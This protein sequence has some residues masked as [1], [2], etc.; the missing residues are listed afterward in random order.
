MIPR[1]LMTR[2]LGL[3]AMLGFE[4]CAQKALPSGSVG[5]QMITLRI[6]GGTHHASKFSR[7]PSALA[8]PRANPGPFN[9]GCLVGGD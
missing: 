2:P 9:L 3:D 6:Q 5:E 7:V 8:Q 4:G 1:E